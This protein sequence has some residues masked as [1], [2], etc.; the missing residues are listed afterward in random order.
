MSITTVTDRLASIQTN[1]AGVTN[2]YGLS[3]IPG[4]LSSGMC[5]ACINVPGPATFEFFGSD[6][7][8]SKRTYIME[9]YITP[10]Q[11]AVDFAHKME[12]AEAFPA[13]F[14]TA[15]NARRTLESLAG[16]EDARYIHDGG[17]TTM[18]YFDVGAWVAIQCFIEVT[19]LEAVTHVDY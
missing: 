2:A 15:F 10:A 11:T 3:E 16:V 9:L 5:P 7:V 8:R 13:R 12:L 19:E 1:I 4:S 17:I 6:M 18:S 14:A